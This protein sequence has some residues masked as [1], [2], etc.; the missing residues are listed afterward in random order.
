MHFV[1][2]QKKKR[3]KP[4]KNKNHTECFYAM[5][6]EFWKSDP[7]NEKCVQDAKE[8]SAFQ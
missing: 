8:H 5:C 7:I 6:D 1:P 4:N 2:M 3:K